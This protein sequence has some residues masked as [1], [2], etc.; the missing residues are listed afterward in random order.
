MIYAFI[1]IPVLLL[2]AGC[3]GAPMLGT[4]E[5][6]APTAAPAKAIPNPFHGPNPPCGQ[7]GNPCAKPFA[8]HAHED[9]FER[10]FDRLHKWAHSKDG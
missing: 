2:F 8:D 5:A 3:T 10:A 9:L 7:K 4:P 1:L 6:A